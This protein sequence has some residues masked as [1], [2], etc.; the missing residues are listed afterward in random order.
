MSEAESARTVRD[1]VLEF[2]RTFMPEQTAAGGPQVPDERVVRLRLRLV[3][4]EAFELLAACASWS[5]AEHVEA[6]QRNVMGEIGTIPIDVTPFRT[7]RVVRRGD[8]WIPPVGDFCV[9]TI[10]V[11]A[12]EERD[13]IFLLEHPQPFSVRME[14]FGLEPLVRLAMDAQGKPT[15]WEI[16]DFLG[17]A[18]L[19]RL[20]V[21]D[22][23]ALRIEPTGTAEETRVVVCGFV[24]DIARPWQFRP[25]PPLL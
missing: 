10:A 17:T 21:Q 14:L 9:T 16:G 18:D 1:H 24:A 7:D 6:L 19:Q 15:R 2:H 4:E 5:N 12:T 20:V 8:S 11:T 13:R 22:G 3:F 23:C 25:P